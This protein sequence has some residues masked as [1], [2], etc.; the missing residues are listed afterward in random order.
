MDS[1]TVFKWGSILR[2][3]KSKT[4]GNR[5]S[6]G[7]KEEDLPAWEPESNKNKLQRVQKLTPGL[8]LRFV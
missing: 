6:S 5:V 7:Q 8:I 4:V 1:F 2:A 3:S